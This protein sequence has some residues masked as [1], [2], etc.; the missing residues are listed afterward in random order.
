MN[1][2]NLT[3]DKGLDGAKE[4]NLAVHGVIDGGWLD[5]EGV[6]TAAIVKQIA[7]HRDA[8]R[9]NVSVNSI[10]GSLWGG[11]ALYNALQSHP[12]AVVSNVH[13]LAASAASIIALAGK[14]VMAPGAMMMIH[15]PMARVSGDASDMRKAAARLEAAQASLA[16]IYAAKTG[17]S[18][19]EINALLE[20]E[21]WMTGEQAVAAKFADE[22]LTGA[23]LTGVKAE[24]DDM[25]IVNSIA[26]PR[27]RVPD[28]IL[29]MAAEPPPAVAEPPEDAVLSRAV[30]LIASG[31]VRPTIDRAFLD[32]HEPALLAALLAEGKASAAADIDAAHA[33]GVAAERARLAAI[34]E[35]ADKAPADLV[36]A[37]KYGEAPGTAETLAVAAL[38]AQRAAGAD[39]LAARR[40]ESAVIGG[41]RPPTPEINDAARRNAEEEAAAKDIAAAAN[42]RR[43]G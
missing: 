34:D 3:V 10:G 38:K 36:T 16:A 11:V 1:V 40:S 5:E 2:L 42:R 35:I 32:K 19:E 22:A 6:N 24:S 23:R 20:A 33:A 8:K 27:D 21:T 7:E 43:G 25:V 26:F 39:L 28:P 18:V 37:A 41:I 17:K 15:P 12:A 9:I 29:A 31:D 14:T 4:L 30:Q 13:G